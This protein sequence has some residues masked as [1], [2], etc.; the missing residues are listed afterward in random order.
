MPN[1]TVRA[2]A[3]A[4][5]NSTLPRRGFL[6]QLCG[7]PFIGGGIILIG[8]PTAIAEPVTRD[9]IW[10]YKS[11]LFYEHRMISYELAGYDPRG[12]KAIEG[13]HYLDNKGSDWHFEALGDDWAV[14][15]QP[16]TRA[17][18]VLSAV[19]CDWRA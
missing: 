7:L 4:L 11:W 16:S 19:G 18:L 14:A 12:A 3:T 5:P 2:S 9:L 10:G 6:R 17:A 13:Y 8:A 15:P 1:P